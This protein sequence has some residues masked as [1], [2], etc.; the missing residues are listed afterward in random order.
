MKN[1]TRESLW[2]AAMLAIAL[3]ITYLRIEGVIT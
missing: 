3:L 2:I 1:E